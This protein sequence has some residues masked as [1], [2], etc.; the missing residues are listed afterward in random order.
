MVWLLSQFKK[1]SAPPFLLK[2]L[3]MLMNLYSHKPN[4]NLFFYITFLNCISYNSLYLP[5]SCNNCSCVPISTIFP[6]SI[7]IILSAFTIVDRRCAMIIVVL[8]FIKLS[9]ASCTC[10]SDSESR[11]LVASS[12]ISNL[13][14][15]KNT[16]AIEIRCFCPPDSPVPL[17]PIMVFQPSGKFFIKSAAFAASAALSSSCIVAFIF[18]YLTFSSIV[19]ENN[20]VS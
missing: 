14:F 16:L 13:G 11:A 12:S 19:P 7:T 8:F 3:F 10:A 15:F 6:L 20:I 4:I 17:S 9:S 5:L 18:P 2:I 1:M